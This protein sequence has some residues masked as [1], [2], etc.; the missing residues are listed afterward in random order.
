MELADVV[1]SK[2]TGSDTVPVRVRPPAFKEKPYWFLFFSYSFSVKGVW[3]MECKEIQKLFIPFI[4]DKLSVSDL[5]AFLD[6][7]D[8]CKECREEYD[9]YYT[10]I[11][12]M[13]Y[14]DERQNI[15][16]FK[17]DSGQ[18]LRSAADY[19]LKY[20]ILLLE[21]Y[22]LLAVLCIGVILLL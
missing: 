5:S 2:S 4:D 10:V 3:T 11:M 14:L 9:I 13:R 18:K 8:T 19:L 12:G 17:L 16:E 6:H 15:S 21:K 22:I 7:M 20:R 1:D